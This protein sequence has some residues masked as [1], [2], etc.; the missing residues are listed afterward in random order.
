[1]TVPFKAIP[2]NIRVPLFYAELD[3]SQA[4][5]A[6]QAQRALIIGQVTG[7]STLVANVPVLSASATEA[8]IAG[9]SGSILAAM[10]AAYRANDAFGELWYLPIADDGAATAAIGSVAFGGPTTAAG[11]LCLYIAGQLVSVA[12]AAGTTGAQAATAASAAIGALVD[13]PVTAAVDGAV[14]SKVNLTARNKGLVGND[15]DVRAN[16]LGSAGG[17]A[18]PAGLTATIVP[19][20]GGATNPSLAAGLTALADMPFDFIVSPY[21]DA[22]SIAAIAA[23]LNDQTGRWSW[24]TQIYGHCFTAKRGTQGALATFGAGLNDQ[25]HSCMGFNDSPSPNYVWA[26]AVAGVAAVSL[27]ADP[28]VPLQSL[29]VAAVL[30]PPVQSRFLLS[31][32]NTLL[33]DGISTFRVDPSGA[34]LIENVITTYQTNAQGQSDSSYLEIETLFLLIFVLRTFAAVVNTKFARV[35]LGSDGVR[36]PASAGVVTPA[37]IKAELIATYRS[38]E[39]QGIVQ[40]SDDFAAALVVQK[41]SSSPSRVDVLL[42]ATLIGQLRVFA[43]LLQ[44]RLS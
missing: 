25:H 35:K 19:M 8:R 5:T 13:L 20:S 26:A 11:T 37:T 42:P 33:Y 7:A 40:N 23:L 24:T 1:M 4:N 44:F 2:A 21:T 39:D 18:L 9:G 43:T 34:V 27:R 38:L 31:Q 28:G 6:S 15:I 10:V 41:N 30:A 3:A 36:Y 32:R 14:A 16:Y 29:V 12:L 22:A 17:Q